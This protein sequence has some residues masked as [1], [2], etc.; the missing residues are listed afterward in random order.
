MHSRRDDLKSEIEREAARLPYEAE[1]AKISSEQE[2][3]LSSQV[4]K[5]AQEMLIPL[6]SSAR[7]LDIRVTANENPIARLDENTSK[8]ISDES[9]D[10]SPTILNVRI[11][12]FD[13]ENGYGLARYD[14]LTNPV[15]FRLQ[16]NTEKERDSVL[17]AMR[18]D[19]ITASFYFVRDAYGS[20]KLLILDQIVDLPE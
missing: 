16:E 11:K 9:T 4:K 15:A 19:E 3:K 17:A 10:E 18:E 14:D 6:R 8:I 1:L 20:P 12:R 7:K 13:R 5:S 2:R